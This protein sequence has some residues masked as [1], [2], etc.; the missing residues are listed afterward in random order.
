MSVKPILILQNITCGVPQLSILGPLLFLLYINDLSVLSQTTF[1]IT[2]ADEFNSLIE[3]KDLH[4]M[5]YDLN[6][7]IQKLSLWLAANKL[8]L[9][10]KKTCITTFINI[11]SVRNRINNIYIDGTQT[12]TVSHIQFMGVIIYNTINWNEYIKYTCKYI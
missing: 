2:Y 7:E 10:I 6:I 4:K 5:E 1:S 12:D 9:N 11:P 3:G 8:S